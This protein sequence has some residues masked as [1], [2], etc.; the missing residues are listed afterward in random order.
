MKRFDEYFLQLFIFVTHISHHS[1]NFIYIY[2]I[3]RNIYFVA[4][5]SQRS[6]QPF[7][8]RS[9]AYWYRHRKIIELWLNTINFF[10]SAVRRRIKPEAYIMYNPII[11]Q[12]LSEPRSQRALYTHHGCMI[13]N[14]FEPTIE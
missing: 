10:E 13:R 12:T 2:H 4:L 5:T 11:Q 6:T 3:T 14:T 8:L 7:Y 9:Y 1:S